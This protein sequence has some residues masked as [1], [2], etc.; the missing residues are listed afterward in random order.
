MDKLIVGKIIK[1][2]GFKG[3]VKINPVVDDGVDFKDFKGVF[4]DFDGEFH[5]FEEVFAV[6]EM[7]GVKFKGVDDSVSATKLIGKFVYVD[8]EVLE[9]LVDNDSFFIE[10]IKGSNVYLDDECIGNVTEIDNFGSADIFYID[11]KKYK[12]LTLPHIVDLIKLFDRNK[13]ALYLNKKVFDE[14]AVY[15]D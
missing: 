1:L 12:N 5:E 11:S 10:D 15:E 7:V 14:V 9:K 3:A 8:R 4:I 13:K 2:H 6:S